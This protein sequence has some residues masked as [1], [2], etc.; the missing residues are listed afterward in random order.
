MRMA[1]IK[2]RGRTAVYHCISRIVGGQF[3][4]ENPCKEKLRRML[5][6]QA[7]F[8]GLQILTYC[9]MSNHFHVLVRVSLEESISDRALIQRARA[10]YGRRSP[11]VALLTQGL[12]RQGNI[13]RDLRQPLTDR[14]GDV[15]V[16]MKELKQRFSKWYNQQTERFGTL[17]AERFK[18]VLVEDQ[19]GPLSD[20]AAYVDLNPVRAGLV[21][22]PKDYRWSG[23]GEAMGGSRPARAGLG[24]VEKRDTWR[25][26]A[27]AYRQLLYVKAAQ[28][29][30]SGKQAIEPVQIR[31]ALEQGGQVTQAQA[32]RLR[33]RYFTDG[34]VLGSEVFVNE[35]FAEFRDRFSPKRKTGARRMPRLPFGRLRTCRSLRVAVYG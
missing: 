17:W 14:M 34:V 11:L 35:I 6:Q 26:T 31:K 32:L 23:Y 24:L 2:I 8:C 25:Q 10:L 29:G 28:P 9:V 21:T 22:D 12:N 4:L 1:R 15:S 16:F 30:H 13:P 3:L 7:E 20:V 27:V 19:P 18:S 5:W 33:I